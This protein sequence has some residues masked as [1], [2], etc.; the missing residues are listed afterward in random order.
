MNDSLTIN[1]IDKEIAEKNIQELQ[2]T[3]LNKN[4]SY[5]P[6]IQDPKLKK[7]IK[8]NIMHMDDCNY[9]ENFTQIKLENKE[10]FRE[11][12]SKKSKEL[13][14]LL[15]CEVLGV[16]PYQRI[17]YLMKYNFSTKF[18]MKLKKRKNQK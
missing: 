2:K 4:S 18:W 14:M 11:L 9:L 15:N 10:R 8:M 12:K 7:Q 13:S 6:L 16:E 1:I 17:A 5:K 3:L